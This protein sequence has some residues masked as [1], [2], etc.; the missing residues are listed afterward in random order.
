MSLKT[1]VTA[2]ID[3]AE[4]LAA[5]CRKAM[6]TS[7]TMFD[8][9]E[10][11]ARRLGGHVDGDVATFGFWTPELQDARIPD[12]DVFL[13]VLSPAGSLDL[14]RAHQS[15][16]FERIYLP[17]ARFE[18]HTFA[19][20]RGMR[21]GNRLEGGDFYA[22]VWRDQNDEWHRILDPLA[23]SLP[24]GALAPAEL[25]DIE[26]LQAERKDKEYW[27]ALSGETPHKFGPPTNILQIHIPTATAG[28]TLASL[29]RQFERLSERLRGDLPKDPS[30]EIY[31]G[32]DAVQLLPVEPT[33]VYETGPGFWNE[34]PVDSD[35][36]EVEIELTR[37]D[38]T[39]WGYDVVI[40][41]MATVN[42]VLLETGRPDELADFAAALHNFP[43]KPKM[44]IFDVV[45]GHSDN[46]GL[47][48]LNSHFFA[49]PNMYG[50]NM[51]YKNPAV[52]SILLEMQR[53]KV[54]FGA[55]GVRVDGAQ[56]FK[57][58]DPEAHELRHDDEFL[59][60]MSDIEENVAGTTYRPWFVFEDGRPWPQEDWE[61]SSTY[62]AVIEQHRDPDVFQWGP[63]TFAHN[64]PFIYGY[65]LSKWWRIKEML[66][67]G[68]NWISGTA[69]HDTLR[70]GTQVNPKLNINTR[71]GE[72]RMEILEKAYDN[73]AVSMLTYAA[74]PGVPM[75]FLNATARANWGF[76][77]NQD[78]QYGV[79][80]VAEEAISL[81][82]Q[83]DEYRYSVPGN[84]R[85]L[86]E[87]GYET[88][89]ELRRFF[90][91]LPALVEVT[92]Y[93]LDHIAKLLNGVEPPLSGP[94]HFTVADLKE[95]A[96]AWMD[97]MHEYCNV[98][99]SHSALNPVQ[100]KF[101][102]ALRNF[103]RANP[104]LRDNL[105]PEDRFDYMQPVDGRT[106]FTSYR[107]GPDIEVFAITHM[108]G[109]ATSDFDPLR[110]PIDG[111]KGAGWRCV[112]RTPGIGDDYISGP[113]VLRDSMGLV[114][115]RTV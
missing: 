67:R 109:G 72:T 8:A 45:F 9:H 13:E 75:D 97:D 58:W 40:A 41:G 55:D 57:W 80:V 2:D 107:K 26:K 93:D 35:A 4:G 63:L 43:N 95:I 101:M 48:A 92:D 25:Y 44:L 54:N 73:P 27:K 110:L 31:L 53:R 7:E 23:M 87:L 105:G 15:V 37:P 91:F 47:N 60:Q 21:A 36:S 114:F 68:S 96:R 17:V 18:A 85:R 50:Q 42:P 3:V 70:R 82:W 65:W 39:N 88:R 79:K 113:I 28:G 38:T 99:N 52:R 11:V 106:V 76:I 86:K 89:D 22:L 90:E 29:T 59:N 30:D 62:R 71:L 1:R 24:F 64:T 10:A 74:L 32:Y 56:D 16:T 77:R 78:D 100:T 20:A 14:T 12:S 66:D 112:L 111:L 104:W 108:E 102:L 84:F 51:D 94:E 61:L 115:E 81:K 33:T 98:S 5:Q 19:A 49:G 46:Q 34:A 83:V 69:N 103:R 6:H